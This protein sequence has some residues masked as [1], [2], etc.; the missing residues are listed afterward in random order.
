MVTNISIVNVFDSS[1]NWLVL[2]APSNK[3]VTAAD[4]R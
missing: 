2:V 1:G 4:F 3:T